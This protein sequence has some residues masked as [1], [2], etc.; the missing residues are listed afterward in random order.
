MKRI[1]RMAVLKGDGI[2]PEIMA[3]AIKVL[4]AVEQKFGFYLE[5]QSWLIGGK[6]YD[7]MGH[8]FP[9][10]TRLVCENSDAILF[11]CIG[12]PKWA[13]LPPKL[14]PER[15]ALLPL[16]R[17]FRLSVNLRPIIVYPGLE[18]ASSLKEH[19]V[20]DLDILVVRE[21]TGGIYFAQPKKREGGS[22]IDTMVYSDWEIDQ[23]AEVA[24]KEAQRRSGRVTS[25]DKA[26][27][28]ESSRLWR[29]RVEEV[30]QKYP[31]VELT[32]LY[33]DNA[34]MQL[35]INPKQFDVLL[36]PNMFGDILSDLA[37]ALT[38]SLGM[39]PSASL[40]PKSIF[41]RRSFG[42][43]EPAGGSAPDI[44]GQGIANPLAQI[45]S[46]ALMFRYSFGL[47]EP[48]LSIENA[49]KQVIEE[50]FRTK[51]ILS[52]GKLIIPV[53]TSKMGSEV[54]ARI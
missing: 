17:D 22:A 16:R 20:R 46:L 12:G 21:L 19:L 1:G 34:A 35:V 29:E 14:T 41:E 15:G 54:A 42:M 33:V 2:G 27:V 51:D 37:A 28:L 32:H 24:F 4:V 23:I 48:A 13:D 44:A 6:A 31:D 18:K 30:S 9:E 39:L 36:C 38:G 11:G 49:V 26:N 45:L 5:R 3:E 50:G 25:I 40:N 8:P 43:Y 53:S 10:E 52:K 47:E 7:D